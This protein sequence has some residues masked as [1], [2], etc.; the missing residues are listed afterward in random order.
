MPDKPN[1]ILGVDREVLEKFL[2]LI[3]DKYHLADK[4]N[5]FLERNAGVSGINIAITN[6]RDVLSHLVTFLS[7]PELEINDQRGQY[8]NAEEHLRRAILEPYEK[9]VSIKENIVLT[10]LKNYKDIVLPLRDEPELS[11]APN[12]VS[13]DAR[14][15]KV[16]HHRK[17]GRNAK[18]ENLWNE[19]WEQ[20]LRSYLDAFSEL[21]DLQREIEE[22][23]GCA[24]TI[25]QK[26][27]ERRSR[28][29]SWIIGA[30]GIIIATLVWCLAF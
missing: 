27:Q 30:T 2:T 1:E 25:L 17:V 5:Y 8:Y 6:Q 13:I 15:K 24:N 11:T 19:E 16:R 29:I 22:C 21:E 20:G 4:A 14:L 10:L 28:K 12:L 7:R 3:R 9:A 23:I 26:K 18:G